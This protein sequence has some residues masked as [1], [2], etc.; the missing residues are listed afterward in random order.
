[1]VRIMNVSE[2]SYAHTEGILAGDILLSINGHPITDVLDYRFYLTEP[3]VVLALL[4]GRDPITVSIR[5]H[6]YDDIGLDFETPLMDRKQS[7]ANKCVF[8]FID[9]MPKGMR[10]SLYFKDDDS[11]LS[12]LHG[13]FITLTNLK[14]ADIDRIL[15]MHISP[16]NISVH[17]TNPELRVKMMK[18]KRAGEVLKYLKT[19]ADAG[20]KMGGQIVL[21]KGLND[22][23]ELTRTMHDLYTLYPAM[24]S[25]SVVPAGLTRY[26][27]GL[28]HLEPYTKEECGAIIDQVDAFGDGC[29]RVAGDRI[30]RC[31]DEFYLT[32]GRPLPGPEFYGEYSQLENG[33][34]MITSFLTDCITE[35]EYL[36]KNPPEQVPPV[37]WGLVT[38]VA[39][40][41]TVRQ[42]ADR[43]HGLFPQVECTV[44]CIE[45]RFFGPS[46]TV[47]GLLTGQD[48][49]AQLRGNVN[50]ECLLLPENTLRAQHDIFLDDMTPAELSE[51]LGVP[52]E[53]A[54][55]DGFRFVDILVGL[56]PPVPVE[57]YEK[58]E[59]TKE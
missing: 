56:E 48:M 2:H 12:F 14:D 31:A 44:H 33:V 26:R 37:H 25:V 16:I 39:A 28:Y 13:N 11:R 51:K 6:R 9:Q 29:L 42:I 34:G 57:P 3:V 17:T 38:G 10:E 43:V 36:E 20:T 1:M 8:C 21:C 4:R 52:V 41:K 35:I 55:N 19:L 32:A 22:G 46:I 15:K 30:F 27:D 45:N 49:L 40:E 59:P 58:D 24:E 54:S 18:N 5:K 50:G 23:D 47:S 7:C 53:I